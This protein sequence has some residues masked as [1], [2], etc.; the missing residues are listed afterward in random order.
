MQVGILGLGEVG[1][2]LLKCYNDKHISVH[3]RDIDDPELPKLEILNICIP[4]TETFIRTVCKQI[5]QTLPNLVIIHSTVPPGTTKAIDENCTC[6]VVHSPVRG[7]HPDLSASLATFIKY[8]GADTG[9]AA[10][11]TEDHYKQLGIPYKTIR[12]SKTTEIAKL[13]CTSYYGMCIAWHDYMA[14]VCKQY[15]VNPS[16]ITEWNNSYNEGYQLLEASKYTRPILRAPIDKKIGGHCIIPNAKILN[17][18]APSKF[19]D[20]L[21]KY[22]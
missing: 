16:F 6:N 8:I 9:R 13:L 11:N 3:T 4:Y 14:D 19:L 10:Q 17:D 20:I 22:C 1:K 7:S 18:V 5:K 21:L 2:S 15:N 12:G